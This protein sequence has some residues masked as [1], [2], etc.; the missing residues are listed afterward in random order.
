MGG[1]SLEWF[2][3][4]KLHCEVCTVPNVRIVLVGEGRHKQRVSVLLENEA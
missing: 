3:Q 4:H 2:K 1:G